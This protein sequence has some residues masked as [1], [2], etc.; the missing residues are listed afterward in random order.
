MTF[1]LIPTL[2]SKVIFDASIHVK[3]VLRCFNLLDAE[4]PS[5]RVFWD[6]HFQEIHVH[7]MGI[8]QLEVLEQIVKER[9]QFNVS[10]GE[11]KIL[12]KETIETTVTAMD[13]LNR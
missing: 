9:F 5:L 7:V 2:K 3:E 1:D 10:F 13:I 12:Y 4:D 11:P 6:E 8:I